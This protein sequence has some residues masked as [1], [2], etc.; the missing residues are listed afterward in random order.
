[1][2]PVCVNCL[3]YLFVEGGGHEDSL[4]APREALVARVADVRTDPVDVFREPALRIEG[5]EFRV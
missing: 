1:M 3:E 2:W 5:A 4:H